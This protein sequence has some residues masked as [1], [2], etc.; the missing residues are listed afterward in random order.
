MIAKRPILSAVIACLT[1]AQ[2]MS[3]PMPGSQAVPRHVSGVTWDVSAAHAAMLNAL[4]AQH[5]L[6]ALRPGDAPTR[7]ADGHARDML[8]NGF[9][10]HVS[11]NGDT[12][13]DRARGQGYAFCHLAENLAKGQRGFET[14]LQ[15]WMN[16]PTH[17]RNLLHS[18]A[19]EFGLVRGVGNL[20]VLVLGKPGCAN[21]AAVFI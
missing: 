19:T 20:W 21:H 18:D 1:L 5:G 4:R 17:R 8:A 11:S 13:I 9:F 12:I 16:S 7:I 14:V 6:P 10:G 15:H 2:C 3:V